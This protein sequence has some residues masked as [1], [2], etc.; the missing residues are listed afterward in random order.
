MK[1]ITP[2]IIEKSSFEKEINLSEKIPYA[3]LLDSET[4][5]T[6]SGHLFQVIKLEGLGAETMDDSN[7]DQ[8]KE[9]RNSLFKSI[10][11]SSTALYF[12]TIRKKEERRLQ[13]EYKEAF[14]KT[15]NAA[16]QKKMNEKSFFI[17]EHYIT[18]VKKPPV[19]KVRR[20]SDMI[21]L[22]SGKVNQ[23]ARDTYRK[24]MHKDLNKM[25]SRILNYLNRYQAYKLGSEKIQTRSGD[26][27]SDVLSFLSELI[28]LEKRNVLLPTCDLSTYLPYKR[29]FFDK[30]SGVLALRNM[31][32]AVEY[33]AIISVKE[34]SKSTAAGMLDALL[35]IKAEMILMQSFSFLD[36]TIARKR[37]LEQQRNHIQSD[38]DS[39]SEAE[40]IHQTLDTLSSSAASIGEHHLSILCKA[41]TIPE[42]EKIVS[43]IDAAFNE[44]GIMAI[45][46]DAGVKP[47]YFAMLPANQ[48]Y[49]TRRA[50]LTSKNLAGFA[51]LHNYARGQFKGNHWGDAVTLL[52][53][54]SGTPFFFNFHVLDVANT[55]LIGSMGSGKTLLEAFLLAQSMKLG[56]RLIVFDKDRGLEIFVRAMEGHYSVM[57][58]GERTGFSPFQMEDAPENRYFLARLL[59]KI[60]TSQ[61]QVLSNEDIDRIHGAVDG[62]FHLPKEERVLRNIVAFLGMRKAG[63][64][65]ARFDAWVNNGDYAWVFDNEVDYLSLNGDIVGFDMSSV[66][67]DPTIC[68]IIYFYLFHRIEQKMDGTRTRIVIAEGWM[69]LQDEAFRR[70]I[71]D[72]SSTPRKK[73]SF[74]ILDTQAPS[75]I[76][77][78]SIGCKIIQE[79]VTQIY[80]A[81]S[82]A[83]YEDYV[84]RFGLSEKEFHIIKTLDKKKRFFLLKQGKLSVVVRADL[85]G[86][87][88]EIAVLSG[89]TQNIKLLD[90]IRKKV[91][92]KPSNWMPLFIQGVKKNNKNYD[93]NN[94]HYNN[95][96]NQHK[97]EALQ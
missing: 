60:A 29:F 28:N 37:I 87:E 40:K 11:D 67:K 58:A 19:G 70:Q 75:D 56:G 78:S 30:T 31:H 85:S 48:A 88:E 4:V 7:I 25:T 92:D 90:A 15:L 49:I 5:E 76:A 16:W 44:L 83:R 86:L 77:A 36:K 34:Y 94:D 13:G 53:T 81:N 43:Q 65:R 46:E 50:I 3:Y 41:K 35:D 93:R 52:E 95:D 69:A 79:T 80:F 38:D 96:V 89:R 9:V 47:A 71:Q 10:T 21:S 18:I 72:W 17:N 22:L 74:L 26:T 6:K 8:E 24:K 61:I 45:R 55:F 97:E 14:A 1:W 73:E 20:F 51:S 82:N 33:A 63:S 66:L 12:H 84:V 2:A 23:K 59:Q 57:S 54:I 64:L 39:L 91:G 62:A 32:S 42:L 27:A 68:E